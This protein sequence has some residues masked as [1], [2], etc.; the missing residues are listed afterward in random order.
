MEHIDLTDLVIE[1]DGGGIPFFQEIAEKFKSGAY[2]RDLPA[3]IVKA[4]RHPR[5][6]ELLARR[7][8]QAR[9][10]REGHGRQG[11][12]ARQGRRR[13]AR[14]TQSPLA[15]TVTDA[16]ANARSTRRSAPR[17]ATSS[18]FQFGK[19]SL[20][21][22]VMANLRVHL[23]KKLG[24]IPEFGHG[25]PVEVPLGRQPA[26]LRVRR[27]AEDL[28]RR[29]PRLHPPARRARRPPRDRSRQGA[30]LPLRPRA[31]RLRDRRRLD[32]PPRS[33]GAGAGVPRARHRRTKT[34]KRS[35]ASCSTR[36]RFGAPPHGGIALGMDR[37][38]MLLDRRREPA[39]RHPVPEDAEGHRPDDG[40]AQPRRR[41]AARRA[42]GSHARIAQAGPEAR[43]EAL[44][45]PRESPR[46]VT[47]LSRWALAWETYNRPLCGASRTRG[48]AATDAGAP[49]GARCERARL[50]PTPRKSISSP[51]RGRARSAVT[52]GSTTAWNG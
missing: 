52:R 18:V 33:G 44:E 37:L 8:R 15:K 46:R 5:Q 39:R 6:R 4:L 40:R 22:T 27:R 16:S 1:H 11:P 17:P 12:R 24:L 30:L 49:P 34:R 7:A 38:A 47:P 3:E 19:E 45:Y 28:G 23:A 31:Q 26:A 25:E 9:G 36:C 41:R 20:V 51:I 50:G 35:S 48:L 43:A 32:P 2:R 42:Q 13:T 10:V 29:A 14:W 21:H